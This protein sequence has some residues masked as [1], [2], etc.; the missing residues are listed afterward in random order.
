MVKIPH[1]EVL[2]VYFHKKTPKTHPGQETLKPKCT[3][4]KIPQVHNPIERIHQVLESMFNTKNLPH[5]VLDLID[6]FGEKLSSIAWAVRAS[7]NTA[8][9]ATPT[10]SVWTRHVIQY[11]SINKLEGFF[12]SQAT[13][14]R[15]DLLERE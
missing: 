15:Q 4:I 6:P 3:T 9:E 5:Q 14:S 10:V 12:N 11:K 7:Y 2:L 8:T 13:I 1:I